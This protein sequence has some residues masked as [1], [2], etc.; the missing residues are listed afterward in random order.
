MVKIII[1]NN[2]DIFYN[3]LSNILLQDELNIEL[4]KYIE[5]CN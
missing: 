5:E 1:A 4:T 2:N 3:S